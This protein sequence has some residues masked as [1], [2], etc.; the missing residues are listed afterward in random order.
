MARECIENDY[1]MCLNETGILQS[2]AVQSVRQR[3]NIEYRAGCENELCSEQD[4]WENAP[5]VARF[6]VQNLLYAVRT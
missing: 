6:R 5:F 1:G 3:S 4:Q 2:H